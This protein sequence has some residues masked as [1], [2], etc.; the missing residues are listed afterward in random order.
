MVLSWLYD[1]EVAVE[2]ML[3]VTRNWLIVLS[4]FWEGELD[5]MTR[6]L[7]RLPAGAH[8]GYDEHYNVYSLPRFERFCQEARCPRG[9]REAV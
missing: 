6:V 8:E 2:Q 4:L 1:Y 5:A 3:G 9:R 7:G